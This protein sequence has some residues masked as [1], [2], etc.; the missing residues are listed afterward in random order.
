[1]DVSQVKRSHTIGVLIGDVSFD[2]TAELMAGIS[3]AG[4]KAKVQIIFLMGM[5]KYAQEYEAGSERI[6]AISHNSVYDYALLTGADAFIIA[7]GSLSGFSGGGLDPQFL[8]RFADVPYVVLQERITPDKGKKTYIVVDN[9]HSFSQCIEHLIVTHGRKKIALVSGPRGHADA[10]ERLCAYM[11]CMRRH[12]LPVTDGMITYGDYSEYVDELVCKLIDDNPDL[13]AIAFANDEMAKAGYRE[14][15]RRGLVVGKEIAITGFD[16]FIAG[17]T[18]E[19]PLTTVSQNTYQMGQLA[20]ERAALLLNHKDAPPI[21]MRTEFIIRHSCGCARESFHP[22]AHN[23]EDATVFINTIID[24][25]VT[26]YTEHFSLD[27]RKQHSTA[28]R[29]FFITLRDIALESP[30]APM[31]YHDLVGYLD[32]FFASFDQ[33]TL[34]LNQCLQDFL[35]H[36]LGSEGFPPATKK[37]AVAVAYMEHYIHAREI[38]L[39]NTKLDS[40]RTQ[41]WIA[42]EL[43]SGLFSEASEENVFRCVVKRLVRSGLRN[44]YICLLETP[45]CR[46]NVCTTDV[47]HRMRLA[48]YSDMEN[49]VT[50]P[51]AEMP[52][53]NEAYPMWQMP[54]FGRIRATMAFSLFSSDHQYGL[55][56]CD[57]DRNKSALMHVIGLQLGMLIDFLALREQEKEIS[58]ELENIREKNEILNFLSEYD[59]LCGLLNRRGFIEQAIRRNRDNIGKTAFCA[60]MDLDYL[61]QIN[62]TFGHSEGDAALMGVSTILK[63]LAGEDD[64][65][66]RIGGDE[67]VGLFITDDPDFDTHF[68]KRFQAEA[69]RYNLSVEKP[70]WLDVSIGLAHFVCRQGLEVS[71]VLAA[72]DQYLYAAKRNRSAVCLRRR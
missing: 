18:M 50:Y 21:E 3:D 44:V 52:V 28:L 63:N 33:P 16:N 17:R 19:P 4:E 22:P 68:L 40:Y 48:A 20:V 13:D 8:A 46:T 51:R 14:C 27:R 65:I 10:R 26:S 66:G 71:S 31:N 60:F 57:E 56:L 1:M 5:Q 12:N 43:T 41:S 36:F 64:L 53:V 32:T 11:D 25:I 24:R 37:F 67:F 39:L 9:Y 59:A 72:A 34:L 6:T 49:T 62:D 7:C 47:V 29:N 38:H 45:I 61:K 15:R 23:Q 70:Y 58:A 55:L 54:G 42:P 2:F 35:L 69:E 30:E